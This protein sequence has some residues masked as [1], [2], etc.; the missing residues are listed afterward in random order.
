MGSAAEGRSVRP[1]QARA[2]ANAKAA[3]G[4]TDELVNRD[5]RAGDSDLATWSRRRHAAD[6]RYKAA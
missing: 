5:R 4:Q 3:A 1:I 2:P 6:L